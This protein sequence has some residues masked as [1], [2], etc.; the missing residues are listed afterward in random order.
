MNWNYILLGAC[1]FICF[2]NL[3]LIFFI[4]LFIVKFQQSLF[5]YLNNFE[6]SIE[7]IPQKEDK[8]FDKKTWDQKYEE[9]LTAISERISKNAEL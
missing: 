6:N 2:L 7:S 3:I 5:N 4:G 8:L 1:L 9:E